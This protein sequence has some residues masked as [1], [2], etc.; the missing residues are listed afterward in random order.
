MISFALLALEIERKYAALQREEQNFARLL[1][2]KRY[3]EGDH[4]SAPTLLYGYPVDVWSCCEQVGNYG[5]EP[6]ANG[7]RVCHFLHPLTKLISASYLVVLQ[8]GRVSEY[9]CTL[10]PGCSLDEWNQVL[11]LKE[12][13]KREMLAFH[14]PCKQCGADD[15]TYLHCQGRSCANCDS[16]KNAC[17]I[18]GNCPALLCSKCN[19]WGHKVRIP[20]LQVWLIRSRSPSSFCCSLW[21]A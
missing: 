8:D 5:A 1:S 12:A 21:I 11:L 20:P 2:T 3:H 9:G 4:L 18:P 13:K 16:F 10:A 15:H 14:R 19:I 6:L 7:A 17:Y